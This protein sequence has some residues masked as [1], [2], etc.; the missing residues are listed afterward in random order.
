[1]PQP[2]RRITLA[3]TGASGALYWLRLLEQLI[4][5]DVDVLLLFSTAGQIVLNSELDLDIPNHPLKLAEFFTKVLNAKPDQIICYGKDQWSAPVASGASAPK[6]MVVCPC[7]T[8]CLSAIANGASDNLLER[9][10]DVVIKEQGKLVLL[11]REM[12]LST[13]HIKNML[14]LAQAGVCVMPASPG[15]YFKPNSVDDIVNFVVGKILDQLDI[16]HTLT[17]EW[18]KEYL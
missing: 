2:R 4:Q 9:A 15:F 11:L 1:M 7:T 14:A 18:S 16:T 13:I 10:A 8:G 6:D 12:P 3:M 5:A 17:P